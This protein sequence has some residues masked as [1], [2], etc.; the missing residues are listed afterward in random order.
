MLGMLGLLDDPG[1]P[2]ILTSNFPGLDCGAKVGLEDG[3][4]ADSVQIS[5]T[6]RCLYLMSCLKQ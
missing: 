2:N 3:A 5:R 4:G 1:K 6:P